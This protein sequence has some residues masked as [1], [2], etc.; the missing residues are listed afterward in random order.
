[1]MARFRCGNEERKEVLDRRRRKRCRMCYEERETIEH[2]W[3]GCS[4]MRER[5]RKERGEIQNEDGKEIRWMKEIW[6]EKEGQNGK[7]KE[8]G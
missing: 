1:M 5:E 4:E 7:R 3:N 8:W 6:K 2:M